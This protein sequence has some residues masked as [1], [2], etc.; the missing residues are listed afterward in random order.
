MS[1]FDRIGIIRTM[2]ARKV[3]AA[4]AGV[5][6]QKAVRASP[7]I[8]EDVIRL[9]G[10]LTLQPDEYAGG[11]PLGAPIDPV[12]L[13]YERGRADLA[14]QI[15]ALMGLT[16]FELTQLMEDTDDLS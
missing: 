9:G 13:S 4:D 6:W 1:V 14:K 3:D 8:M 11:V 12:R 5:R 10:I 7:G 15:C 16:P 2:F